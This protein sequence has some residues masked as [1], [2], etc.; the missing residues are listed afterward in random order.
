MRRP[1][2][3]RDEILGRVSR[4]LGSMLSTVAI[5]AYEAGE[6][7]AYR[8]RE[9][10]GGADEDVAPQFGVIG[11]ASRPP[12]GRGRAVLAHLG[13]E[14]SDAVVIATSDDETRRAIVATAGL[15]WD[16]LILHN[17]LRVVKFTR[18]GDIL[19]GEPGGQFKKV[20]TEDHTHSVPRLVGQASYGGGQDPAAR[21]GP[22]DK[23]STDTKVT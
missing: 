16:E 17:S 22:P 11:L 10:A 13:G 12:E 4:T 18:D 21:T 8:G 9:S 14:A 6:A 23:V 1:D 15:D 2:K 19:I 7:I 20:A 3:F 5:V